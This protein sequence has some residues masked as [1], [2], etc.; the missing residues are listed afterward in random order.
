ML[1]ELFV[2]WVGWGSVLLIFPFGEGDEA[3]PFPAESPNNRVNDRDFA[4]KETE[5]KD[6][7]DDVE[8][9]ILPPDHQLP[10]ILPIIVTNAAGLEAHAHLGRNHAL[11]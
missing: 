11:D 1:I 2:E 7:H 8:V 9:G 4:P 6:G 10:I 3:G 5:P